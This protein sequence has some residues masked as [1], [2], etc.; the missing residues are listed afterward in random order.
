MNQFRTFYRSKREVARPF[1]PVVDAA[2]WAP[3]A[4]GNVSSWS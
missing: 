1:M 4:L 2:G 3:E